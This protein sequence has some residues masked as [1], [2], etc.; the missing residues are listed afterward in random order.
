MEMME[1]QRQSE[2]RKGRSAGNHPHGA[3][4]MMHNDDQLS[5]Q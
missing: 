4:S 2:A 1:S 3:Q 5:G